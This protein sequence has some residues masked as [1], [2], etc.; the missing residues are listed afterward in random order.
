MKYYYY[1]KNLKDISTNQKI[2]E[3][4]YK[5]YK[6]FRGKNLINFTKNINNYSDYDSHLDFIDKINTEVSVLNNSVLEELIEEKFDSEENISK[7]GKV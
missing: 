7:R 1:I 2:L 4:I 5:F 6:K 3:N